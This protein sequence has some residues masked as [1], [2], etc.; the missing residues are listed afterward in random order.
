[1]IPAYLQPVAQIQLK[2][3][4]RVLR[5]KPAIKAITP[6]ESGP[7]SLKLAIGPRW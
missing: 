2:M 6:T 3:V 5:H 7:S 1:M 4:E